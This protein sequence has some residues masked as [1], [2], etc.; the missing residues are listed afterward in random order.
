MG[1]IELVPIS[2]LRVSI[3]RRPCSPYVQPN[4][5]Y[6]SNQLTQAALASNLHLHLKLHIHISK[7]KSLNLT[8][9]WCVVAN[10]FFGSWNFILF[11][12]NLFV[13]K[14]RK[15]GQRFVM[16]LMPIYFTQGLFSCFILLLFFPVWIV[17]RKKSNRNVFS[18]C[19]ASIIRT[20]SFVQEVNEFTIFAVVQKYWK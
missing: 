7:Y 20:L 3:L 14:K 18:M 16:L 17:L 4:N 10:R 19:L 12:M 8:H 6:C 13:T 5:Q 1:C 2:K 9:S 11:K 15:K